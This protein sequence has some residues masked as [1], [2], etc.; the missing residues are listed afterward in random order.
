VAA[1]DPGARQT[2]SGRPAATGYHEWAWR[3]VFTRAFGHQDRSLIARRG[4][5]VEGVLPLVEIRSPLFGR[6]LTSMPFVNYGGML[7]DTDDSA[8]GLLEAARA[9]ARAR[10]CRH[11]ELR[12][13]ARQFDDLPCRQHKVS[14]WLSLAPNLWDGFD[15]KVRNQVRKAE[16]S[17]LSAVRG[18]IELLPEFYTVFSRNMRDLGTPVYGRELFASVLDAFPDRARLVVVR[19]GAA[20]VA[21]G[22]T[23][24]TG[25]RTE[26]PWASSIRDYNALCPNHLLYWQAIQHAVAEGCEIFDFGRSTPHEGTYKFKEQWGAVPVPLHW[27]YV[28]TEGAALPDHSPKN[29]KFNL[30][31]AA[32]KR[33]PLWL[34][35]RIGPRIVKDI[36]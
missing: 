24:R 25:P 31:I 16:K 17:Q 10:G 32:W 4:T 1:R 14:M 34:A 35:N 7:A 13:T 9:L 26:I 15:R 3:D 21:A 19:L 23:Y 33:S 36:P 29:P 5:T 20:P 8:R 18:G 6:S 28:L 27:E 11:V 2:A 30:A 12:H 22:L